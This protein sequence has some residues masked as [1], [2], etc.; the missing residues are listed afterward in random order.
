MSWGDLFLTLGLMLGWLTPFV[1]AFMWLLSK[2]TD[3][4]RPTWQALLAI[5]GMLTWFLL[6]TL[7][8]TKLSMD[9]VIMS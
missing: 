5:F 9:G 7:V 8:M 4:G 3:P 6:A 2:G 1:L